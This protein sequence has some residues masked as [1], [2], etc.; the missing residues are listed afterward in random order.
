MPRIKN[1]SQVFTGVF[2][3]LV[4]CLAFYLTWR[5]RTFSELGIGVGFV[6]RLFASIQAFLGVLLIVSG[7]LNEGSSEENTGFQLRPLIVLIAIVY[8]G[9]TIERLGMVISILGV[10]LISTSA[11]K[12]TRIWEAVA[13]AVG[14]TA[15]C[16]LLFSMAL[17]LNIPIWPR[18]L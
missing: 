5:F 12:G 1:S 13:L 14:T 15:T 16:V 4:A 10:V 18:G 17:G 3:I 8:F 6:P 11:N 2:L 9:V 7:F